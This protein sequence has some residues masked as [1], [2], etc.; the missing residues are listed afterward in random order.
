MDNHAVDG[1][2]A[3]TYCSCTDLTM[4]RTRWQPHLDF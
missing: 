4:L 3:R 1:Q 2:S